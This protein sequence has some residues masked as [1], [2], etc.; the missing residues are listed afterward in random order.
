MY[1]GLFFNKVG[2]TF[3]TEHLWVTAS[4]LIYLGNITDF[5]SPLPMITSSSFAIFS[6]HIDQGNKYN[7]KYKKHLQVES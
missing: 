1:Q 4:V 7:S 6:F 5:L 2:N 3:F